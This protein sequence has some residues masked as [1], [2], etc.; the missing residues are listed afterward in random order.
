M[1]CLEVVFSLLTPPPS[2]APANHVTSQSLSAAYFLRIVELRNVGVSRGPVILSESQ[3][4]VREL[5]ANCAQ[6]WVAKNLGS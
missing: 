2:H 4:D 5:S 1:S 6:T 3:C